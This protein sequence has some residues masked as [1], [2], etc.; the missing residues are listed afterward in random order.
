MTY[1]EIRNKKDREKFIK[2]LITLGGKIAHG[3]NIDEIINLR[4]PIYIDFETNEINCIKNTTCAA[5]A[6]CNKNNFISLNDAIKKM[7]SKHLG[8]KY[9]NIAK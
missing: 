2:K 1:I 6:V 5:A 7:K 4:Y 8:G 3:E 9:E